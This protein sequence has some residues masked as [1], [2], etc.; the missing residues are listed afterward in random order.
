ML[1]RALHT[2]SSTAAAA[3]AATSAATSPLR[4]GIILSRIPIV[5]PDTP[6]F[7]RLF[8]EYQHSLERRLMWTFPKWYYFK[9]GTVA[10]RDFSE[11][12]KYPIPYHRGVWFPQ[13]NPDLK[14]ARDRRFPQEVILPSSANSQTADSVTNDADDL[15]DDL[16]DI[17]RPIRPNPRRTPADEANDKTSLERCLPRTLYLVVQNE[18]TNSWTFPSFPALENDFH[19]GLHQISEDGLRLIGGDK[20]NSWSVSNSPA[21]VIP[22]HADPN[23]KE[24]LFK[25]HIVAGK[26]VPQKDSSIKSYNWLNKDELKDT[27]DKS[28]YER[29]NHLLSDI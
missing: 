20:I 13:G 11:A 27:L 14:H 2:S 9:R 1:S 15:D 17:G 21:A 28:Y 4:A 29:V 8:Y 26:F 22:H 24:F 19:K 23:I 3:S 5:T 10:E 16:D 12:Q 18:S 25:S 6:E 7:D